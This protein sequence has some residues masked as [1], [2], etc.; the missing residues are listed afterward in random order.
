MNRPTQGFALITVLLSLFVLLALTVAYQSVTLSEVRSSRASTSN[1]AAFAAAEGGLNIRAQEI[2]AK[3]VGYTKPNG[4]SPSSVKPCQ[5]S[6]LGSGDFVCKKYSLGGHAVSTYVASN[7]IATSRPIPAGEKFAGLNAQEYTYD[8][9]SVST[10]VKGET[11]SILHMTFQS[12]L[13]PL[14]QFAAFFNK[15]L[16]I[17]PGAAMTLN[18]R[19]HTNSTLYLDGQLTVQGQ[20]TAADSLYHKRKD[21]DACTYNLAVYDP[22]N[23]RKLPCTGTTP[24]TVDIL[25]DWNDQIKIDQDVLTVP[26]S[27]AVNPTIGNTYWDS[28]DLRVVVNTRVSPVRIELRNA[29]GTQ[30]SNSASILTAA[31]INAPTPTTSVALNLT[32]TFINNRENKTR[33][34]NANSKTNMVEVDVRKLLDLLQRNPSLIAG[35]PIST[36]DKGGLVFNFSVDAV[37]A[38]NDCTA[39]FTLTCTANN[40]G[41]RLQNADELKSDVSGAPAIRGLTIVSNQAI[42]VQGDYN[43]TNKKPAAII[44]DAI[45]VLSTNWDQTKESTYAGAQPVA[46]ETTINAA[47]LSGTDSTNGSDYS[48]GLEN[49]PRLHEN[50]G[51]IT[52]HYRGSFV[53]LDQPKH[54]VGRWKNQTYSAAKRDWNYDTGFDDV[55]GLP[56]LAPRFVYLKQQL[57]ARDFEQ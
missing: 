12:R 46:K 20:V 53:N 4:V 25:K 27:D 13:V 48:G 41:I 19:I 23:A 51:G 7:G 5:G 37:D 31:G 2:R 15:D 30:V 43:K 39:A 3:F 47:F 14:F 57:F 22:A 52:L 6:N 49:Y 17:I 54:S 45:N 56:P 33:G 9:Y 32:Q 28:A 18:G 34:L 24:M 26:N 42:Y 40:Y 44:A 50:W 38:G 11:E 16:E 35:R 10:N 1:V 21:T 36:I 55:D 8:V 29:D